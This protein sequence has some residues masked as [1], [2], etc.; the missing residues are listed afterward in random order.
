MNAT[1]GKR[2]LK[3]LDDEEAG[4]EVAVQKSSDVTTYDYGDDAGVGFEGTKSSDLSIP[5]LGV[6]QSNSPQVEDNNPDGAASGMLYNTVTRE[7]LDGEKGIVFLPCHKDTAF[8]EWVPRDLGG[9]FVGMHDPDGDV[10]KASKEAHEADPDAK[11]GKYK[12]GKNDLIETYYVYGLILDDTGEE[13]QGFAVI[14]FTSTKIKAYRDWTTA[15]YTL[16]GK[17]PIFANRARIRTVKQKN[18]FGTF[19]NFCIDPLRETWVKSLISPITNKELL[20][21]ASGFREMVTSG[22]ARAAFET[23]RST[24]D[25]SGATEETGDNK[26]PF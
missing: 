13:T 1:S 26:V 7:L 16:K 3:Q 25:G 22:M 10:V 11:F 2:E 9:G 19:F 12:V 4:T 14:S 8:V 23:E 15:M 24:G 18:D 20:V 5:F 21:E 17:P 6:L